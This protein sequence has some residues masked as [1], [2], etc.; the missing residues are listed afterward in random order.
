MGLNEILEKIG[1]D[2]E[3]RVDRVIDDAHDRANKLLDEA[4]AKASDKVSAAKRR[5]E[6]ESEGYISREE[7]RARIGA[8][9]KYQEELNAHVASAMDSIRK[10]LP[11]YTK[12]DD[13]T[14]LLHSL[15][16]RAVKELG[17]DC[18]IYARQADVTKIKG[19]N[20]L[21]ATEHF[22]GGL[23]AVSSD[24]A[25]SVDYTLEQV[26]NGISDSI[27]VEILKLIK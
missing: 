3:T 7:S 4:R 2:N 17:D 15:A 1:Q 21:E 19:K 20:V 16:G 23:K 5:A 9:Q 14:K 11:D 18:T 10:R 6:Q 27:A 24:G 26:L 12:T 8:A 13:Y 25:R 22:S